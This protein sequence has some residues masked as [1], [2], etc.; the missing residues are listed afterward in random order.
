M[1]KL[2][3]AS[4]HVTACTYF[5]SGE[6]ASWFLRTCGCSQQH[7]QLLF[8][9][10]TRRAAGLQRMPLAHLMSP[11]TLE[12]GYLS[13]CSKWMD[14]QAGV[15]DLVPDRISGQPSLLCSGYRG[16]NWPEREA[17]Y[18]PQYS[19][20][21]KNRYSYILTLSYACM[22]CLLNECPV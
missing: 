11:V 15:R 16:V 3:A 19:N 10:A 5:L 1:A 21:F 13:G 2:I 20:K 6:E 14:V 9:S 17:N 12:P 8:A 22:K 4:A 7:R 18:L